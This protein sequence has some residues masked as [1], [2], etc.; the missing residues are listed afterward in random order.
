MEKSVKKRFVR[1]MFDDIHLRYDLINTVLSFGTDNRWRGKTVKDMPAGGL[2]IDICGGGGQM[3]NQLFSMKDFVGR[4]VIADLSP[5]MIAHAGRIL[6]RKYADRYEVVVC[7]VERLPFKRAAF[8]GAIS[9]FGLRN[10]TDLPLF[11]GEMRRVLRKEGVAKLLEIGHPKGKILG[12]CSDFISIGWRRFWRGY[13]RIGNM[14]TTIFP[15]HLEHFPLRRKSSRFLRMD[16]MRHRIANWPVE[17]RL[18]IN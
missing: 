7:D 3:A 2:V 9:G 5:K 15:I 10:L 14:L 17:W 16:G 11:T 18:Y 1:R 12:R 13:L 6:D 4:V 8:D